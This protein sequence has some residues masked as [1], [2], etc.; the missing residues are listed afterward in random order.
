MTTSF[1][2]KNMKEYKKF[3]EEHMR[4]EEEKKRASVSTPVQVV[5]PT[6]PPVIQV[7]EKIIY[8]NNKVDPPPIFHKFS[9]VK[10]TES[11]ADYSDIYTSKTIPEN[12]LENGDIYNI[13]VKGE[14]LTQ[15]SDVSF[16]FCLKL[17]DYVATSTLQSKLFDES[18]FGRGFTLNFTVS[19]YDK[20]DDNGTIKFYVTG[21]IIVGQEILQLSEHMS[22]EID[23]ETENT[24]SICS[25]ASNSDEGNGVLTYVGYTEKL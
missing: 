19:F 3:M 7:H 5:T 2:Y 1:K 24:F 25:S 9:G 23:T 18:Q 4:L 15:E 8:M 13:K 21:Q 6:N 22:I 10:Y 14:C 16:Q 12:T 20:N 11:S 17:N